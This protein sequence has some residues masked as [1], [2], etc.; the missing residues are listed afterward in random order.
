M[1]RKTVQLEDF[2]NV[3]KEFMR[4]SLEKK[5]KAVLAGLLRSLPDLVAA[6]PVDTGLYAASWDVKMYED[7]GV[8]GN[9]APYASEV[10]DG[11][12]PYTPP[13]APLLAWAKRRLSGS[14]AAE[15]GQPETSYTPEVWAFAKA[16]QH[17]IAK[18]GITPKH[19]ME[20]SIPMIVDHIREELRR[21]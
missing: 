11:T 8:I 12:R 4:V 10:E 13:I 16:V 1:I 14:Q 3:L 15:T 20:N 17:K 18:V 2:P 19:I 9:Y 7:R 6:S 5:K 21:A